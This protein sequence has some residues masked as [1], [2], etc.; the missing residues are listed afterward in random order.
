[1]IIFID[2]QRILLLLILK[3]SWTLFKN[4][5]FRDIGIWIRSINLFVYRLNMQVNRFLILIL[6][7][8]TIELLA[9]FWLILCI[10]FIEL[11]IWVLL[12]L[13]L[14]LSII[15]LITLI[16]IIRFI[17]A[18]Q[19]FMAKHPFIF[20]NLEYLLNFQFILLILFTKCFYLL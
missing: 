2:T 8:T 4:N 19:H 6:Y 17:H 16:I 3:F 1:M 11:F 12:L 14:R 7:F 20:S 10:S 15:T 18:I 13:T 9:I 5:S